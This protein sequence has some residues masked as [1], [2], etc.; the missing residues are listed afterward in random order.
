MSDP[1]NGVAAAALQA[2]PVGL[3]IV[4]RD[5]RVVAWNAERERGPYGRPAVEVVG[6][7][8]SEVLPKQGYE[9]LLPRLR[10]IFDH[11]DV[12]DE[13]SQPRPGEARIFRVR[14]RPIFNDGVVTH[15]MSLFE[16]VSAE[17]ERERLLRTLDKAVQTMPLGVTVTD[18]EGSILYTGCTGGRRTS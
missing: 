8:L 3:Y 7:P 14:R 13:V 17:R 2:L 6:K 5:L 1:S 9:A 4:D 15:V 11:S 12:L 10:H 18:V 16:D